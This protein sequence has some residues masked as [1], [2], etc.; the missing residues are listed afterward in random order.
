MR[1][2]VVPVCIG[3]VAALAQAKEKD[4]GGGDP[5]KDLV[6]EIN[7]A[8]SKG[9]ANAAN[10]AFA[11]AKGLKAE[12][13]DKKFAPVTAA[14]SKG[15]T[16]KNAA[17]ATASIETLGSLRVRGSSK[18]LGKLI[19]PAAKVPPE[20]LPIVVAAI[21]AAGSIGDKESLKALQKDLT[22][23]QQEISVAAATAFSGYTALDPK[24]RMA[25]VKSLVKSLAGIEKEKATAKD[26]KV[27]ARAEATDTA[28]NDSIALITG[29]KSARS[30]A[31]WNE[32]VK[33]E[34]KAKK[35]E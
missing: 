10:A 14:I 31:A 4:K 17:I 20:Q 29:H 2:F 34:A 33:N 32:W 25:L 28:L 26:E 11:R 24:P 15:V 13:V 12:H 5:I 35:P 1:Y 18:A 22:H 3:L 21:S 19:A 6:K 7:T 30:S 9:D 16:S 27:K 8:I 23:A